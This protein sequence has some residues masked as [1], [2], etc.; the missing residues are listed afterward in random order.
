MD[1]IKGTENE[2]QT[3]EK[4]QNIIN[5]QRK[6]ICDLQDKIIKSE[7]IILKT[8]NILNTDLKKTHKIIHR[9]RCLPSRTGY[10]IYVIGYFTTYENAKKYIPSTILQF[11]NDNKNC[12]YKCSVEVVES[13]TIDNIKLY[14]LL[15][16]CPNYSGRFL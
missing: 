3:K 9:I 15:N 14:N 13:E 16:K 10:R 8:I 12:I 11:N 1:T 4:Y 7:K 5:E 2:T 6:I